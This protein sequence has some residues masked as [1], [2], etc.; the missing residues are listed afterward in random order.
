MINYS[1]IKKNKITI[2]KKGSADSWKAG[3]IAMALGL[4]LEKSK[5][6]LKQYGSD[7]GIESG[8]VVLKTGQQI[9]VK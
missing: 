3:E 2:I 1:G 5:F 9:I 7:V 6:K 4:D 8:V